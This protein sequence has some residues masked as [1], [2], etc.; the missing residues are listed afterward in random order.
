MQQVN[1]ARNVNIYHNA[2]Y[3]VLSFSNSQVF[4]SVYLCAQLHPQLKNFGCRTAPTSVKHLSQFPRIV[5]SLPVSSRR[6]G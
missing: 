1:I 4:K 2:L 6:E 3:R 5:S